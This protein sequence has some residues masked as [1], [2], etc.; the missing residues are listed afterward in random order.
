MCVCCVQPSA[1][2][3]LLTLSFE[4]HTIP[5]FRG[6]G[7]L[8]HG[9]IPGLSCGFMGFVFFW[10]SPSFHDFKTW[11]CGICLMRFW[12]Q[13]FSRLMLWASARNEQ[14]A[15][16]TTWSLC[17]PQLCITM[18]LLHTHYIYIY[19]CAASHSLDEL[20][21]P[22]TFIRWSCMPCHIQRR[23]CM[24][25]HILKTSMHALSLS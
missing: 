12:T 9:V 23:A 24:P 1:M 13:E 7:W 2:L 5:M 11:Y 19:A 21:C 18:L 4:H 6:S 17:H 3:Q 10:H 14:T 25:C 15:L 16:L 22:A 8:R 20:I